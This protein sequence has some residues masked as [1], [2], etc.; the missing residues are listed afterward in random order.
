MASSSL[1]KEILEAKKRLFDLEEDVKDFERRLREMTERTKQSIDQLSI[2]CEWNCS[3]VWQKFDALMENARVKAEELCDDMR[4]KTTEQQSKW[5]QSLQ[6]KEELL[7]EAGMWRTDLRHLLSADDDEDVVCGLQSVEAKL[8]SRLHESFTP[9]EEGH[10]VVTFPEWCQRSLNQIQEEMVDFTVGTWPPRNLELQSQCRLQDSNLWILSIT[11]SDED[12]HVFVVDGRDN[13]IKEFTD[14]GE[15]V[16]QC[17]FR[18]GGVRFSPL[19]ICCL[20]EDILVV[21]GSLWLRSR[22][23]GGLF[24]LARKKNLS[25][26]ISFSFSFPSFSLSLFLFPFL[27]LFFF[28]SHTHT[29]FLNSI[30]RSSFEKGF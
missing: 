11:G 28:L 16:G 13:S 30:F 26:L 5:R 23:V 4:R 2:D 20:S 24:F 1:K 21:C 9:V 18:D 27:F 10:F 25:F 6:E 22:W 15:F 14:S 8:S 7:Q 3:K 12:G 29:I 17:L 19:D